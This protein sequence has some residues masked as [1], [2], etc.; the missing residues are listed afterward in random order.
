MTV[1]YKTIEDFLKTL[2]IKL[3]KEAILMYL[4]IK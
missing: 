3:V 4:G 1:S 2:S